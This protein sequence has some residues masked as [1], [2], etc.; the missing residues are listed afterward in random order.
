MDTENRG[1]KAFA[2]NSPVKLT[3]RGD[4]LLVKSGLKEYVESNKERLVNHCKAEKCDNAYEVQECIFN[5]F[6]SEAFKEPFDTRLKN[7]AYEQGLSLEILRRIG[8]IYCRDVALE[9]FHMDVK[10]IDSQAPLSNR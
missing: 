3:P 8:A 2:T 9:E 4:E 7:F 6:D 1:A 10:D 5:L